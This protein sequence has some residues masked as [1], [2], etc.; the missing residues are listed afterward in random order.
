[1]HIL[2]FLLPAVGAAI[3][4][5]YMFRMWFLVFARRAAG[6]SRRHG[7]R[8]RTRHGHGHDDHHHGN[9]VRPRPRERADHD[10]AA[11]RAGDPGGL[12]RLDL[13]LGLP[14]GSSRCS[15]RCSSYGEPIAAQRPRV[16]RTCYALGA[17]ILIATAGIGAGLAFYAPPRCRTS[18]RRRFD[19]ERGGRRGSRASTSSS[20]TS[21]TSTSSTTPSSSA[22]PC[23]WRAGSA[24]FDKSSSTAW[25]TPRRRLTELLSRLEGLFDKIAVDGLVNL[26]GATASTRSATG[27]DAPDRPA[28]QLPDGPGRRAGR[29]VRGRLRLGPRLSAPARASRHVVDPIDHRPRLAS[30]DRSDDTS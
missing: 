30:R 14:F 27:P 10:L 18:V 5:F 25:S 29:P 28:P 12:H 9:P 16:D 19:A 13:D 8:P 15:S 2:L 3:T 11:D 22:R 26:V 4:A 20:C 17:S 6:L 24:T 23:R 21:G 7:P 1:M